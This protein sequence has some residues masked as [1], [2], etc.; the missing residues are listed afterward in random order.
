MRFSFSPLSWN[1]NGW[2]RTTVELC[3][4]GLLFY[5][6]DDLRLVGILIDFVEG[7][8]LCEGDKKSAKR[9]KTDDAMPRNVIPYKRYELAEKRNPE[10]PWRQSKLSASN[11]EESSF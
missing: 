9:T 10:A 5:S 8:S 7:N 11:F 3:N 6:K 4:G 2:Y 1:N